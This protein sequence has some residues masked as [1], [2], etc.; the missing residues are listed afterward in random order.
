[1]MPGLFFRLMRQSF[2]P[3]VVGATT[4]TAAAFRPD[5][6]AGQ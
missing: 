4:G 1:L 6:R 5:S 2:V 3:V